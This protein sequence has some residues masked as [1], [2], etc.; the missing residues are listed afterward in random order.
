VAKDSGLASNLATAQERR[1]EL[2]MRALALETEIAELK[3]QKEELANNTGQ[4]KHSFLRSPEIE[5][6][7]RHFI[8]SNIV[9]IMRCNIHGDVVEVNDATVRMLGYQ[10]EEFLSGKVKWTDITPPE[11]SETDETAIAQVKAAGPVTPFEKI[12]VKKDKTRIPLLI[13]VTASDSTGEDCLAFLLDRTDQK[14]A[15]AQLKASESQFRLLA[16]AIPQIVWI[17][18][19]DGKTLYC[20][21]RFYEVLGQ[22]RA[23]DDGYLW[24]KALH[25]EDR[26]KFFEH[27]KVVQREKGTLEIKGRLRQKSGDYHWCLFRAIPINDLHSHE[28]RWFGTC[29]DIEH[30]IQAEETIRKSE[31]KFRTLADAIPQIVWTANPDG[32]ID[33]FN[34]RWFE[35][36]GLT[37]EQSQNEG[38]QLLIHPDDMNKYMHE[39]RKALMTGDTYEM[40]FRLKRAIGIGKSKGNPYRWHLGRAVALHGSDGSVVKWFATW[41]E[42]ETQKR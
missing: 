32:Q 24:F 9:P 8:D 6:H 42:I 34:H 37:L 31:A 35:Y 4:N 39:W 12:Y 13:I 28:I 7:L 5:N 19:L 25:P 26:R 29:T 16:E 23:D 27:A 22:K 2:S 40:E 15:E 21:Q 20:N 30:Q 18:N 10:R 3:A 33:F 1:S 14:Q 36:T 11:C 38:W 41:T 17:S